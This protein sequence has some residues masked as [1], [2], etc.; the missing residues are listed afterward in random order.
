[1]NHDTPYQ[2]LLVDLGELIHTTPAGSKLLSEPKLAKQLGVSRSTLREAMRFFETQGVLS[3]RRGAGTTV[4]KKGKILEAGLEV[5]ESLETIADRMGL[6]ISMGGLE[7]EESVINKDMAE[8]MKANVGL[9]VI[10]VKRIILTSNRPIA[11]LEDLVPADMLSRKEIEDHFTGSVLDLFIKRGLPLLSHSQ[12]KIHA[13]IA[14]TTIAKTLLIQRGETLLL[15][16]ANLFSATG[17]NIDHSLS[18]FLPGYFQFSITR[19]I[20]YFADK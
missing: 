12:T 11:Y 19:K 16:E 7:I 14:D 4:I 13:V 8:V 5:L 9:P 17:R 6:V 15:F 18:Y 3:R 20:N 1:M 2:R 10:D